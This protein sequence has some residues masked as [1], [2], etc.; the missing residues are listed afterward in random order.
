MSA[1]PAGVETRRRRPHRQRRGR[2][3]RCPSQRDPAA[4]AGSRRAPPV[5]GSRRTRS[6]S[7]A[8]R[9]TSSSTS[10]RSAASA[11]SRSMTS[12]FPV[13]PARRALR[14][15]A[16]DTDDSIGAIADR[17]G[18]DR[19]T[20]HRHFTRDH[21]RE[22]AA[23]HT[24]R[25]LLVPRALHAWLSESRVSPTRRRMALPPGGRFRSCR[26][27]KPILRRSRKRRDRRTRTERSA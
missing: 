17:I 6:S 1:L 16:A 23:D 25:R 10:S 24:A 12:Y 8:P 9:S 14:R 15:L 3:P 19:C 26:S 2:R 27:P 21:I 7:A 22:E 18:V 11:A 4:S 13:E 5:G 20:V